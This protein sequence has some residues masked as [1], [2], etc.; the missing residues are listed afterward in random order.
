M[1]YDKLGIN[2]SNLR[3]VCNVTRWLEY[4]YNIWPFTTLIF[5]RIAQK[6]AKV[7]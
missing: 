4:S 7:G 1:I 2:N 3:S 5:F 6:V